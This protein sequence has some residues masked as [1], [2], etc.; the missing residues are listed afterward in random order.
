MIIIY[1]NYAASLRNWRNISI[2]GLFACLLMLR[3]WIYP[4]IIRLCLCPWIC[5]PS[6]REFGVKS[7]GMVVRFREIS[8]WCWWIA[9]SL[10]IRTASISKQPSNCNNTT[11]PYFPTWKTN[12][13]PHPLLARNQNNSRK[14]HQHNQTRS[15]NTK[16]SY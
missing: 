9:T 2:L 10:M 12:P 7:I 5:I 6:R 1:I 4:I 3:L 13:S 16:N 15:Y 11:N 14:P 8:W